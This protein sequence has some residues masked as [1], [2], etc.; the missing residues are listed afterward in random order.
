MFR[1]YSKFI[2]EFSTCPPILTLILL[3]VC[4]TK[5]NKSNKDLKF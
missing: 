5:S 4:K 3:E 1:K 2:L